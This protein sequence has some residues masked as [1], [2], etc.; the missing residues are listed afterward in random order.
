MEK[1]KKKN[2]LA[3]ITLART[4]FWPGAMA[5]RDCHFVDKEHGW[6]CI[7]R[8]FVA[9]IPFG[10]HFGIPK[11][12][13]FLSRAFTFFVKEKQRQ[14]ADQRKDKVGHDVSTKRNE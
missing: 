14:G 10:G 11:F 4:Y 13:Y 1:N 6:L 5:P 12:I 9:T 8:F 2:A 3:R 7:I